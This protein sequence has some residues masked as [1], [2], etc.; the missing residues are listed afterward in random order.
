MFD[1]DLH[2]HTRFFHWN[3]GSPTRFDPLGARLLRAFAHWR[4][5]DG[6]ALTNHDY[7]RPYEGTAVR[8]LPGIEVETTVGD[9]L[10]V[11]PD[12][13]TDTTAGELT[14]AE[15][16]EE[17]HERG[18]AAILAHPYRDSTVAESG[19]A[20]DAVEVN[21]KHPRRR[22]RVERL[23]DE[24]GLPLVGGSDAHYPFEVGR[25]YTVVEADALTPASVVDAV[26]DGRVEVRVE[27]HPVD[28]GLREVYRRTHAAKGYY[29]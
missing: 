24:L 16:V 22:E 21:G 6:I 27:N 3:R 10:V 4:G 1:I 12:P 17:A 2:T 13:L 26:R 7:Y 5:L 23:A 28:R 20:F 14:P 19:A 8:S 29:D 18:C 9:V 25:A 11:G 15:V